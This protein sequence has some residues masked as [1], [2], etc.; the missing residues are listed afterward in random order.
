[1]D[2][3][4]RRMF[5]AHWG[6]ALSTLPLLLG[7][8]VIGASADSTFF[9]FK[10]AGPVF[11]PCAAVAILTWILIWRRHVEWSKR[12]IHRTTALAMICFA[13]PISAVWLFPPTS[14]WLAA[15]PII[16]WGVWMAGTIWLWPLK[17]PASSLAELTP[18]CRKC[19]YLLTGLTSTR[20]PE[21]GDEP[22]L[23]DLWRSTAFG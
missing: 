7:L 10:S 13:V 16:G 17:L 8:V 23:D 19:S 22:T 5:C 12:A 4:Y 15:L 6:L 9:K 14:D 2:S 20:C 3:E 21:C 11:A 18:R 1:M